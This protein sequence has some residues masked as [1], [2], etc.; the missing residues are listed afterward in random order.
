MSEEVRLGVV[1][2]GFIARNRHILSALEVPAI[3][4]VAIT[5]LVRERAEEW[6]SRL[7]AKAYIS[8]EEMYE[9]SDLK[10]VIITTRP[11]THVP[12]ALG[13][14]QRRIPVLVEKPLADNIE[15]ARQAALMADSM[16][17]P[18]LMGFNKRSAPAYQFAKQQIEKGHFRVTSLNVEFSS[19]TWGGVPPS[20]DNPT[21]TRIRADIR[22]AMLLHHIHAFDLVRYFAGEVKTLRSIF[23]GDINGDG[24]YATVFI[25][26]S[27]AVASLVSGSYLSWRHPFERVTI[28]GVNEYFSIDNFRDVT[29]YRAD[30]APGRKYTPN[31]SIQEYSGNYLEGFVPQLA[32]FAQCIRGNETPRA[33]L[34][35]GYLTLRLDL[36]AQLSAKEGRDLD[37]TELDAVRG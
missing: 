33:T 20:P 31:Y 26:E 37:P 10:G 29:W 4:I 24:C 5:D 36:A 3:R 12:L 1:G 16:K 8:A 28:A 13:A 6:A 11:E 23:T 32:H 15:S 35:D 21:Y 9:Q 19:G 18:C 2:C 7:G 22:K 34:R 30:E 14:M 27:G 25:T 17:L